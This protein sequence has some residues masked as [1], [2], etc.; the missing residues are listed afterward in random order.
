MA[1]RV[2]EADRHV[3]G[4]DEEGWVVGQGEA[5]WE[6]LSLRLA[7]HLGR[8]EMRERALAY[9]RGVLSPAVERKNGWQ[10]AEALGEAGPYGVQH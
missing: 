3:P 10:L 9:V 2:C 6:P 5:E 7:R 1:A 4:W 8:V